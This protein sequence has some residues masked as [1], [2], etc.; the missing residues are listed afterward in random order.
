MSEKIKPSFTVDGKKYEF[1]YNRAVQVEHQRLTNDKK[2]DEAYQR[3]IGVYTRL[4][5]EYESI[6]EAYLNSKSAWVADPRNEDKKADYLALKEADKEA[7]DEFNEF[8]A[9]HKG[10]D[11]TYEYSFYVLGK[12]VLLSLQTRY[13]L[14][15]KQATEI[16]NKF[17]EESGQMGSI[18]WLSAVGDFIGGVDEDDENPTIKAMLRKAET[19]SNRKAGLNKI[20]K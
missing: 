3:D 17:V 2:Q 5:N 20:N 13:D 1:V 15:E 4:K 19:E 9:T 16:W 12:L 8:A 18:V 14:D 6:H 10:E 7:F 11:E